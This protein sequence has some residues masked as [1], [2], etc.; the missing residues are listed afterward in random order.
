MPRGQPDYGLYTTTEM[1]AG[2]ADPGE[3]AARLGSINVFDRRGWTLWMDDFESP[4]I[5]WLT[6]A[7]GGGVT[8]VLDSS[9]AASGTQCIKLACAAAA[10]PSSAIW[11]NFTLVRRGKI[12]VEFWLQS[13][14][15]INSY[16]QAFLDI[17]DGVNQTQAT[18]KYYPQAGT[19]YITTPLGDILVASNVYMS[20]SAY[21]FLP[22]KLVVDMDA[23]LYTRLMVGEQD[24]DISSHL[25]VLVGG[26][27]FKVI[28]VTITLF[29]V[30][31]GIT[32]AYADNFIFT[33][34]EP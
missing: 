18:I 22:I 5:K 24:I 11:R 7:V 25:Q 29:G 33:V 19:I 30:V 3:A 15:V 27:A 26:T 16:I 14:S 4:T 32:D 9:R 20:Q 21:Y 34:N 28:L 6:F 8:P 12:G 17:Y 23:D 13:T 1:P 2:I 10:A 31:G